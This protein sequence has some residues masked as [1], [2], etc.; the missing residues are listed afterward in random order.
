MF[1]RY[2]NGPFSIAMLIYQRLP[3]ANCRESSTD[4]LNCGYCPRNLGIMGTSTGKNGHLASKNI[5]N[6]DQN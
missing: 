1:N 5:E 3:T 6:T 4:P 2:L